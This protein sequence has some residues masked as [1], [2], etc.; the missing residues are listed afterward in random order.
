PD[1]E[2]GNPGPESG[3]VRGRA[4]VSSASSPYRELVL[5]P[6]ARMTTG[7]AGLRLAQRRAALANRAG[8]HLPGGLRGLIGNLFTVARI[9][10]P[11]ACALTDGKHSIRVAARDCAGEE[12]APIAEQFDASGEFPLATIQRMGE[13]G[14]MG[15]EVP[16]AYGGSRI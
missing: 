9:A 3:I 14:L 4:T 16:E 12:I 2:G 15:I 6:G 13:L 11:V 10:P 1:G 7:L 5:I 8:P